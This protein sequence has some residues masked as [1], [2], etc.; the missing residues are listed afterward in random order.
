MMWNSSSLKM[1]GIGARKGMFAEAHL[2]FWMRPVAWSISMPNSTATLFVPA[3]DAAS[4]TESG[5]PAGEAKGVKFL[6]M[7][8]NAAVYAVGS[9]DYQFQSPL[10]SVR[11]H[12][13]NAP[14]APAISQERIQQENAAAKAQP[15][16]LRGELAGEPIPII[17]GQFTVPLGAWAPA[18]FVLP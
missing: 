12:A 5:K 4:V 2:M 14:P 7:E 17:N 6:R 3:K 18:S 9:G 11:L 16:N 13:E 1:C 8:N 15:V 10:P